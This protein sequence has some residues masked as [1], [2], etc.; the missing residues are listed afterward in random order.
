MISRKIGASLSIFSAIFG[1]VSLTSSCEFAPK[2]VNF[3]NRDSVITNQ[4]EIILDS[5]TPDT[6]ILPLA[7]TLV[8]GYEAT[9]NQLLGVTA[10]MA[11]PENF[12]PPV[13]IDPNKSTVTVEIQSTSRRTGI[14]T[15]EVRVL[16]PTGTG[17][18]R[19][20]FGGEALLAEFKKT[21]IIDNS[22]VQA[23]TISSVQE[24]DGTVFVHWPKYPNNNLKSIVL[25]REMDPGF[26]LKFTIDPD[27]TT[28]RDSSFAGGTVKYS[29]VTELHNTNAIV[30]PSFTFVGKPLPHIVA[31]RTIPGTTSI[32]LKWTKMRYPANFGYYRVLDRFN[33]SAI[34]HTGT[35]LQ[36]TTFVLSN[37][38]Q[39]GYYRELMLEIGTSSGP[40]YTL[41][42]DTYYLGE[43]TI[44][45]DYEELFFTGN[46]DLIYSS[47][48]ETLGVWLNNVYSAQMAL[49][50]PI[51]IMVPHAG[52]SLLV[53]NL[54]VFEFDPITLGFIGQT[55]SSYCGR[56]KVTNDKFI[57]YATNEGPKC[58]GEPGVAPYVDLYSLT[59][60][61]TLDKV[62]TYSDPMTA[63]LI[64]AT[65]L[66]YDERSVLVRN[67]SE[68]RLLTFDETQFLSDGKIEIPSSFQAFFS[69]IDLDKII[70]YTS[71]QMILY[72]ISSEQMTFFPF[73]EFLNNPKF[74]PI[75][76]WVGGLNISNTKYLIFDAFTGQRIWEIDIKLPPFGSNVDLLNSSTFYLWAKKLYMKPGLVLDLQPS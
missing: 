55:S 39:L 22:P 2:D 37:G 42:S 18:L 48:G 26:I 66:G 5:N 28:F 32:E 50:R 41:P 60:N 35:N 8:F 13:Y 21:I 12:N 61:L 56:G 53:P 57:I 74:D 47:K 19:E 69:P 29:L 3:A 64:L 68:F 62:T 36:D 70:G 20:K 58:F 23:L 40:Y 65:D 75:G 51:K 52:N 9:N 67:T 14:Y 16:S 59:Q 7:T 33:G 34:Y 73:N 30:G 44:V 24:E 31:S 76:G 43:R 4:L 72:E 49:S 63:P 38:N 27:Q 71:T 15:L 46:P 10:E 11:G 54:G 25:Q 45:Q 6:L 1:V 17:S